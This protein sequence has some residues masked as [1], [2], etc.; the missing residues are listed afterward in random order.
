M[1]DYFCSGNELVPFGAERG[2]FQNMAEIVECPYPCDKPADVIQR[3]VL[4]ST[5]GPIEHIKTWCLRGHF[6]NGPVSMLAK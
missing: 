3:Y 6:F 1:S 4:E 5:D 2:R